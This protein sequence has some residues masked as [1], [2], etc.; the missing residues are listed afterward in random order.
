MQGASL[1]SFNNFDLV[2][3]EFLSKV[4]VDNAQQ[5]QGDHNSLP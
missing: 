5:T 3:G 4:K 2:Y 1:L